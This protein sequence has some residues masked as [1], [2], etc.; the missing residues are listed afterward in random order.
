LTWEAQLLAELNY[1]PVTFSASTQQSDPTI[2]TPG[3]F[4]WAYTSLPTSLSAQWQVGTDNVILHAA[5]MT[6]QSQ[7]NLTVT[8]EVDPTTWTALLAAASANSVDP[9]PYNYVDVSMALPETLTLYIGGHAKFHTLVNTGAPG[10]PTEAGTFGVYERFL[11]TTMSGTNPDG[12]HYSDPGI[13]WVSYFNG[14]DALH[15]FIRATYG[16]PQSDG[17]V[18]MPFASAKT[19]FPHT[20]IGTLVTVHD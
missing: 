12:S 9:A 11:T 10:A 19:V 3:T 1:L 16:W 20:P 15:G 14:G 17:C 5:M 18:E 6:F 2:Q 8:G 7:H 4:T 13:P